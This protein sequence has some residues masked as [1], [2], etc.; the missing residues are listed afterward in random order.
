M[1]DRTGKGRLCIQ[2]TRIK[3]KCRMTEEE[4]R[5]LKG[6]RK[7]RRAEKKAEVNRLAEVV[8]KIDELEKKMDRKFEEMGRGFN[9]RLASVVE[10]TVFGVVM[11]LEEE[12]YRGLNWRK[13]VGEL[14]AEAIEAEQGSGV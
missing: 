5:G 6:F 8:K 13:E 11:E 4:L 14:R 9:H 3:K 1:M 7:V 2:C 10:K 12:E